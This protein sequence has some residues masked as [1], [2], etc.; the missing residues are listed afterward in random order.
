LLE[1]MENLVVHR[2]IE[3]HAA[4]CGDV[5]ALEHERDSL[6]YR[7]LNVRANG[8]ARRLCA[9]GFQRGSHLI[10]AMEH[11]IDLATVLLAV[12][13][14]GGTFAWQPSPK[15]RLQFAAFASG[16]HEDPM[17][18]RPVDLQAMLRHPVRTS[19]NLPIFTR[20][21]DLA[22]V[23]SS[24][25]GRRIFV[26]HSTLTTIRHDVTVGRPTWNGDA[27]TFDLWA[28][29]MSGATVVVGATPAL[30]NAA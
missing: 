23:L 28:A 7:E 30:C 20:P 27:S 22:C 16:P 25:D 29:L 11:G 1:K 24:T 14:A 9:A 2:I 13:K 4:T 6:T 21:S 5:A 17:A 19:P 12:L 26:P 3:R 18:F 10:V 15:G 8:V